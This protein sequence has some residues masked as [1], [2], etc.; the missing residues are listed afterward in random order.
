[1]ML[2]NMLGV[3]YLRFQD[4]VIVCYL[5]GKT[6]NVWHYD[7]ILWWFIQSCRELASNRYCSKIIQDALHYRAAL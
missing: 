5:V 4:D 1:M 7:E 2:N 3:T 6:S